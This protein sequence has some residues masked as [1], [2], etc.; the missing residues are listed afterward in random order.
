MKKRGHFSI[1]LKIFLAL[2]IAAI[3]TAVVIGVIG[4]HSS[5]ASLE[6]ASFNQLIALRESKKFAVE[7]YFEETKSEIITLAERNMTIE[8]MIAFNQSF[9]N[10]PI[11]KSEGT[12]QDAILRQYY[13]NE[14]ISRLH[15]KI[16]KTKTLNAYIPQSDVTRHLQ[17]YY[18]ANNRFPVDKKYSLIS[19]DGCG[20]YDNSH[21]K[22]HEKYRNY[23]DK[24]NFYNLFLIDIKTGNIVYSVK[25]EIDFATSL[26]S[27]P[28]QNSNLASAFRSAAEE[29]KEGEI[30]LV[31]YEIHEPSFGEPAAFI[32]TP[33]YEKGE[34]I[35]VIALQ[36]A[37]DRLD[38]ILT[39][40][41]KWK[42][43]GFGNTGEVYLIGSD[44][45]MRSNSR[46]LFEDKQLFLSDLQKHQIHQEKI[47]SI[48]KLNTTILMLEVKTKGVEE[49]LAGKVGAMTL[50]D[51]RNMKVLSAYAPV[52]IDG[53]NWAILCEIDEVESLAPVFDLL[54][55]FV[56]VI[57]LF[58][59][60]N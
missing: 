44:Y 31:D 30:K 13:E 18:I 26:I 14:F 24:R 20:N 56:F 29:L 12:T 36:L 7:K 49:A 22:Y 45:R 34:K 42:E 38:M 19:S 2:L 32:A 59:K 50:T 28:F 39:S 47:T 10:L 55:K 46:F 3:S 23:I 60:H 51:Y 8:A 37:V 1:R 27:G 9:N 11:S 41:K 17:Y 58:I 48:D 5:K 57:D 21:A 25:K 43:S 54:Y 35:G 4:Y 53:L 6:Q 40:N 52:H 16:V 15:K 33:I